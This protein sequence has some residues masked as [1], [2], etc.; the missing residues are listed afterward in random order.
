ML[1][2]YQIIASVAIL[3]TELPELLSTS[4]TKL[5]EGKLDEASRDTSQF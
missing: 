3:A 4:I 2:K 1:T 5:H